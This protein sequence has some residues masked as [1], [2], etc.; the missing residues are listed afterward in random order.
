MRRM[1]EAVGYP[2]IDLKRV[3]FGSIKLSGLKEGHW[4]RLTGEE[5]KSLKELV[6]LR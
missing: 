1:L 2:V 4:R 6:G 5:I 3:R